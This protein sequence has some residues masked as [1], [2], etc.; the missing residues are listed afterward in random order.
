MPGDWDIQQRWFEKKGFSVRIVVKPK[1][2]IKDL[3]EWARKNADSEVSVRMARQRISPALIEIQENL[4]LERTPRWI[5]G[6]DV[7]NLGEKFAVGS[8]V[9]FKDG[10]PYKKYYRRYRIRRIAGQDDFAMIRQ[11]VSRRLTDI[12]KRK[13]K[14]GLLLIDGG[15]GQ[16]NSALRVIRELQT[17]IPTFA[18]AKRSDELFDQMGRVISMPQTGKGFFVL[19]RLRDEAHRFAI[20]Y[21]RKLR[22][23]QI[24]KSV[25]DNISGIGKSRK[26]DIL[27]YFGSLEALR[28]AGETEIA[29]VPGIG[30]KRARQIYETLHT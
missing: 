18:L 29:K 1:G 16:L 27:R 6:F 25:L 3:L 4:H 7:S 15:K 2:P 23:K 11:I 14:P 9:A 12:V 8:S 5:E 28:K 20:G 21:H 19:K 26:R 13:R 24:T 22:G 30:P 17:D 10:K